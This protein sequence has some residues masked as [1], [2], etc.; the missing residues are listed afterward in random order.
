[1]LGRGQVGCAGAF[2]GENCVP[3]AAYI[4]ELR[5]RGLRLR[6]NLD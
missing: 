1:M 3:S 6:V 2:T 4:K 5:K